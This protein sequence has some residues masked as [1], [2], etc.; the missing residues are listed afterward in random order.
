MVYRQT[1]DVIPISRDTYVGVGEITVAVL[2]AGLAGPI[3]LTT[4]PALANDSRVHGR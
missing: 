3:R 2:V 1:T 4:T